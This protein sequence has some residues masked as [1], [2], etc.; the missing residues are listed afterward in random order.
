MKYAE[1]IMPGKMYTKY[2]ISLL[3]E[4]TIE[5]NE[6]EI[7]ESITFTSMQIECLLRAINYMV[8]NLSDSSSDNCYN[9]IK[10]NLRPF[11]NELYSKVEE[12]L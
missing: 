11:F 2:I 10:T 12:N 8:D 3:K 5:L 4:A 7:L 1:Q 9:Y 6:E